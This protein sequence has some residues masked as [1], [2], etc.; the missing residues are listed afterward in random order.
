[1]GRSVFPQPCTQADSGGIIRDCAAHRTPRW[2]GAHC[3]L[4]CAR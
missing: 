4:R 1:M 3:M 2:P